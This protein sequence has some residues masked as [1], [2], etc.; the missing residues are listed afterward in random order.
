MGDMYRCRND[1]SKLGCDKNGE[2]CG[3]RIKEKERERRASSIE[4]V[5]LASIIEHDYIYRS[6]VFE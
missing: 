3:E 2:G 5:E 1:T 4:L 6:F